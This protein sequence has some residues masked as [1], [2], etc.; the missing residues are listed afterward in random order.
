[1]ISPAFEREPGN[2]L[3]GWEP[4]ETAPRVLWKLI[5]VR[6]GKFAPFHVFWD[7]ERWRP[8]EYHFGTPTHWLP[9]AADDRRAFR[10]DRTTPATPQDAPKSS[11]R[12]TND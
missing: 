1:M 8:V 12:M 9:D 7:G 6:Q 4:I 3:E 10:G 11:N 5:P 2:S